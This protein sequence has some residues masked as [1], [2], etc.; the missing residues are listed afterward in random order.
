MAA[1]QVGSFLIGKSIGDCAVPL[2][3]KKEMRL[4]MGK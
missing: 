4:G 1:R 3:K 2:R